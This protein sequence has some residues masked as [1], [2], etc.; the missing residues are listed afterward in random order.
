MMPHKELC[1]TCYLRVEMLFL[2]PSYYSGWKPK[3]DF[4]IPLFVWLY[5]LKS[6]FVKWVRNLSSRFRVYIKKPLLKIWNLII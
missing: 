4:F 1:F 2:V 5:L 3:A 6:K